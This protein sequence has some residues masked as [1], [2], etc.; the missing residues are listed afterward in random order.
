MAMGV[1]ASLRFFG[2][3][4]GAAEGGYRYG[5]WATAGV[6]ILNAVLIV[7]RVATAAGTHVP[8]SGF[9]GQSAL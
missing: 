8:V 4:F 1:V 5:K 6:V 7:I 2:A 3:F 9:D